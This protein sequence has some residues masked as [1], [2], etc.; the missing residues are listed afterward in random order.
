MNTD[1]T[2]QMCSCIQSTRCVH[3]LEDRCSSHPRARISYNSHTSH[4]AWRLGP[5]CTDTMPRT[6]RLI[7]PSYIQKQTLPVTREY[8]VRIYH[9]IRVPMGTPGLES[10]DKFLPKTI[11]GAFPPLCFVLFGLS[12]NWAYGVTRISHGPKPWKPYLYCAVTKKK[13]FS[14][15]NFNFIR[16]QVFC[17]G[18]V[19]FGKML[20][21]RRRRKRFKSQA[22]VATWKWIGTRKQ[23]FSGFWTARVWFWKRKNFFPMHNLLKNQ[24]VH[25]CPC[26][27]ALGICKNIGIRTY[28]ASVTAESVGGFRHFCVLY[29]S[30]RSCHFFY[31]T[32]ELHV[33]RC[34]F[35]AHQ[36]SGNFVRLKITRFSWNPHIPLLHP[37][38]WSEMNVR[39]I[40]K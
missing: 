5:P 17:E 20:Q 11:F 3:C 1:P 35:W 6:P 7:R 36:K 14:P 13:F 26:S 24:Y 15:T 38:V 29:K 21:W 39:I 22:L 34:I 27:W 37:R 4:T 16:F 33:L 31:C 2:V 30:D 25:I 8:C 12:S 32:W 10:Y 28:F 40:G 9:M 19:G 18:R 23:L